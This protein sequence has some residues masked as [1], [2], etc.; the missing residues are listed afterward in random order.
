MTL[1]TLL[2]DINVWLALVLPDHVHRERAL[3]WW[4][5]QADSIAFCR[6]TQLGLLRLLTTASVMKGN[7]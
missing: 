6:F 5:R 2:P 1:P 3:T 4:E 7:R